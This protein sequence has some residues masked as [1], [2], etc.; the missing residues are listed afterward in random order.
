MKIKNVPFTVIMPFCVVIWQYTA[1][2]SQNTKLSWK[3]YDF[4]RKNI[5]QLS[6]KVQ[7]SIN[8]FLLHSSYHIGSGVHFP[9]EKLANNIRSIK[10]AEQFEFIKFSLPYSF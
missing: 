4:V 9:R 3:L 10:T 1:I 2:S 5:Y 7:T 6:S 8:S